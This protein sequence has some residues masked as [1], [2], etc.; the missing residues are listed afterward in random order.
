MTVLTVFRADRRNEVNRKTTPMHS[1]RLPAIDIESRR[2]MKH[3]SSTVAPPFHV[4]LVSII[5]KWDSRQNSVRQI[6]R[7]ANVEWR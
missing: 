3:L 6:P 5:W 7:E 1:A 2:M 4:C